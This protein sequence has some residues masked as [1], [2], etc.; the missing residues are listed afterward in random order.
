MAM[1]R[2]IDCRTTFDAEDWRC[3]SCGFVPGKVGEWP[4]FAADVVDDGPKEFDSATYARISAFEHR[5]FYT[6]SRL[7]LIQWALTRFFPSMTNFYD[8]GAGTLGDVPI[9]SIQSPIALDW[10][11]WMPI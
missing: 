3:P 10:Y 2:C 4:T 11:K 7:R 9:G 6:R 1:K 5:S 8:F